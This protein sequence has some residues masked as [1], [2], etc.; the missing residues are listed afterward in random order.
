[1][2]IFGKQKSAGSRT[3]VTMRPTAPEL[4]RPHH[5]PSTS[6]EQALQRIHAAADQARAEIA[7]LVQEE[8]EAMEETIAAACDDAEQRL[9]G[10][11]EQRIDNELKRVEEAEVE[12]RTKLQKVVRSEVAAELDKRGAARK[13]AEPKS[14]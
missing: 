12:M 14:S 5:A 13:P 3:S 1:M 4:R 6:P 7:S 10:A 9:R 8:H 11:T 2:S